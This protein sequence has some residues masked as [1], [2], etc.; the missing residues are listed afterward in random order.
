MAS[1]DVAG[2]ENITTDK[3]T[4]SNL[5]LDA[6]PAIPDCRYDELIPKHTGVYTNP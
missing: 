5:K 4:D 6:K 1:S 2:F 3:V